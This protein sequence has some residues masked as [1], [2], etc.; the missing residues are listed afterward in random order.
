MS[1][2][3]KT[4]VKQFT[5]IIAESIGIA[6]EVFSKTM[7]VLPEYAE[8]VIRKYMTAAATYTSLEFQIYK[9]LHNAGLTVD[10]IKAFKFAVDSIVLGSEYGENPAAGDFIK[11]I[12]SSQNQ[13]LQIEDILRNI[14]ERRDSGEVGKAS[15]EQLK[16][17]E[18]LGAFATSVD[19]YLKDKKA[20]M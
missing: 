17:S 12:Y 10:A 14:D 13:S 5:D 3:D 16:L 20:R 18:L 1:F 19:D 15:P 2:Q 6:P 8:G 11:K 7:E 4:K 9:M